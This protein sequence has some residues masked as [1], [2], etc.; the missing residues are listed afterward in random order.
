MNL[1]RQGLGLLLLN[2]VLEER[3][4]KAFE[5]AF[6]KPTDAMISFLSKNYCLYT[7]LRQHN[8]FVIFPEFFSTIKSHSD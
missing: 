6:D 1:Q 5:C 4:L 2:K 8:H 7:P 3:R